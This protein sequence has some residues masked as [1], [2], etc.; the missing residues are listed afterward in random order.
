[1]GRFWQLARVPIHTLPVHNAG[2]FSPLATT[3]DPSRRL[4]GKTTGSALPSAIRTTSTCLPVSL[5]CF[6]TTRSKAKV[7]LPEASQRPEAKG[8]GSTE[9]LIAGAPF[10][11]HVATAL[12]F[13]HNTCGVTSKRLMLGPAHPE[14]MRI[15]R[16]G[17]T[18]RIE[19]GYAKARLDKK[20]TLDR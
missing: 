16:A 14:S 20:G 13:P 17:N 18:E 8:V 9:K 3:S 2:F 6:W 15:S 11:F 19:L 5:P 7:S 1:M 12:W 4:V 10:T